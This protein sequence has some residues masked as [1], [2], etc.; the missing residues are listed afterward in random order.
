MTNTNQQEQL[1]REKEIRYKFLHFL[2]VQTFK[3]QQNKQFLTDEFI[4]SLEPVEDGKQGGEVSVEDVLADIILIR[5]KLHEDLPT[6]EM[7]AFEL[8]QTIKW[9][10][11][12]LDNYCTTLSTYK[13]QP[14]T[15]VQDGWVSVEDG[16]PEL[17]TTCMVTDAG[18][19]DM[20]IYLPENRW[21]DKCNE[22]LNH[23]THWQPLPSPPVNKQD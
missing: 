17:Y 15:P 23:V 1:Y 6:G 12:E 18:T 20:A 11:N 22:G 2:K 9:H 7:N 8:L 3:S 4:A 5:N 10:I 21:E 16:L 14:S 13:S 19:V